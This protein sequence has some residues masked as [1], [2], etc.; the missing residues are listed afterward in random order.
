MAI[1]L[2]IVACSAVTWESQAQHGI[3]GARSVRPEQSRSELESENIRP[4]ALLRAIRHRT[5]ETK[6]GVAAKQHLRS[7]VRTPAE[8]Y[9]V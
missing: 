8:C 5:V 6:D 2:S 7:T 9:R 4:N 3:A 1:L